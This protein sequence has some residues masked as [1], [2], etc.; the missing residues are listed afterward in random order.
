MAILLNLALTGLLLLLKGGQAK[1]TQPALSAN[2]ASDIS[3]ENLLAET[4]FYHQRYSTTLHVSYIG[5][6]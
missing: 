6:L 2:V 1:N 5:S 3:Q 4:G